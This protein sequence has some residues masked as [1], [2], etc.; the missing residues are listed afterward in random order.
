MDEAKYALISRDKLERLV[1]ENK[2]LKIHLSKLETAEAEYK[3]AIKTSSEL[4]EKIKSLDL[5]NENQIAMYV[6]LKEEIKEL[7]REIKEHKRLLMY[8]TAEERK[9]KTQLKDNPEVKLLNKDKKILVQKL[10]EVIAILNSE[11]EILTSM[12]SYHLNS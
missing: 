11:S 2:L 4:I 12:V 10:D 9:L 8:D 1:S 5:K 7:T 3:K 6:N